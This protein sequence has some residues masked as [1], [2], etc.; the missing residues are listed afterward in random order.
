M[1][2]IESIDSSR[3]WVRVS[4]Q[5]FIQIFTFNR[6][7]AVFTYSSHTPPGMWVFAPG[8]FNDPMQFAY[9]LPASLL[10]KCTIPLSGES[11]GSGL[12]ASC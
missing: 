4:R 10:T 2:E 11:Q 12:G 6:V 8:G 3:F 5:R 9:L 7:G 1:L